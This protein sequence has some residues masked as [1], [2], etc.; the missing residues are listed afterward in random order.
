[1]KLPED[2]ECITWDNCDDALVGYAERCGQPALAVYDYEKLVE[3]F[4]AQG[5]S[6]EEAVEWIEFNIAGAWVGEQTPLLLHRPA[7]L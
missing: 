6:Q 3:V 7:E 4:L 1:M 5:M 2:L